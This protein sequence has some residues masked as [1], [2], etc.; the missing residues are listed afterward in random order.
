MHAVEGKAVAEGLPPQVR[1]AQHRDGVEHPDPNGMQPGRDGLRG[2]VV[3]SYFHQA[4]RAAHQTSVV[5]DGDEERVRPL[6]VQKVKHP[7]V[8]HAFSVH[9]IRKLLRANGRRQK[10]YAP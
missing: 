4:A 6:R 8:L 10:Q 7:L 9:E 2:P 3:R 5:G 1:S